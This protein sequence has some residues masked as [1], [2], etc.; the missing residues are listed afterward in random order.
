MKS[1]TESSMLADPLTALQPIVRQSVNESVYQ[2]LRNK[3]MHG[4][5]RAGQILGIQYLADALGIERGL[6][7]R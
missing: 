3:L 4:E 2:A 1:R 5:Y 6:R 7:G